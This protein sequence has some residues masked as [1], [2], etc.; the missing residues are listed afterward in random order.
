[1]ILNKFGT[2][3][4]LDSKKSSRSLP[5][6][7]V[8]VCDCEPCMDGSVMALLHLAGSTLLTTNKCYSSMFSF[9]VLFMSCYYPPNAFELLGDVRYKYTPVRRKFSAGL[10][11]SPQDKICV[12]TAMYR[13]RIGSIRPRP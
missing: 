1:M 5:P 11:I 2:L 3:T 7:L 12:Y 8:T 9:D 10:V 13:V 4:I 6:L